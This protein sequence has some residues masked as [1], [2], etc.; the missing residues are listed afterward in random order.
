MVII[1]LFEIKDEGFW[2]VLSQTKKQII[3]SRASQAFNLMYPL[4]VFIQLLCYKQDVT[5]CQFS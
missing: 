4:Y 3:Y 2:K 1:L 5:P